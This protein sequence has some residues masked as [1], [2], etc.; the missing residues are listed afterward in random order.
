MAIEQPHAHPLLACAHAIDASLKDVADVD[1]LFMPSEEKAEALLEVSGLV[2]R[3]TELLLRLLGAADDVAAEHSMRDASVYLAH[4]TRRD[5]SECRRL[6]RLARQLCEHTASAEALRLGDATVE[7]VAV[8]ATSV[9][10][11]PHDVS[12]ENR[13]KAEAALLGE[14]G[15]L[16]PREL[17]I[18]G[19]RVLELVAPEQA[20]EWERRR[21]ALEERDIERHTSLTTRSRGDG[22]TEIRIR[23]ADGISSRLM[24]YL[25][26]FTNPRRDAQTHADA[27][28]AGGRAR[29]DQKLGRA[30]ASFVE[31]ADP[32][33][34]PLHGG[35][36]T[37]VIV[38]ID[39]S[40][41]LSGLG[42]G[43]FGDQAIS[44]G[45]ARR[46]ACTGKIIPAVLGGN[47]EIL[48]LGRARRLF[49][50]AQRKALAVRQPTCRAEG[51]DVPAPWCEAHH[52]GV[53]WASGG[54]TDLD[55]GLLLCSFHHHR[56][57]SPTHELERRP[58]GRV[59][60]VR[61]T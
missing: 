25:H 33:R 16:A 38:T 49:S 14:T 47:S 11:L 45:E 59:A 21:L 26:A 54:Q 51:C 35:D 41:L 50:P 17:G 30:F 24:T 48:D 27:S 13:E 43:Q 23:T 61:R 55:D 39:L 28:E 40:A 34:M 20:E 5:R 46:L 8:I 6:L 3:T 44:A 37:S 18:C 10:E 53:P 19:R 12:R 15:N 58:H 57:H 32:H 56:A 22:T 31:N 36:A 7:Q 2:E 60:F 29:Y 1:P 42:V 52:A 4:H 9:D